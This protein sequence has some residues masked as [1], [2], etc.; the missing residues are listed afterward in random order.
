[1]NQIRNTKRDFNTEKRLVQDNR[2]NASIRADQSKTAKTVH[3]IDDI[4]KWKD[5]K[6]KSD[7]KGY[8]TKRFRTTAK[9][10]RNTGHS[11]DDAVEENPERFLIDQYLPRKALEN[12][13]DYNSFKK[14]LA[15]AYVS[16][17]S[18]K[19]LISNLSERGFVQ[20][21]NTQKVQEAVKQ[22]TGVKQVP[23]SVPSR[24]SVAQKIIGYIKNQKIGEVKQTFSKTGQKVYRDKT[25]RF[26]SIKKVTKGR[27]KGLKKSKKVMKKVK[28]KEPPKSEKRE[29]LREKI[30]KLEK[31][32]GKKK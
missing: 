24:R 4:S 3:E 31:K 17:P 25:G 23:L 32:R 18:L 8:D 6:S 16:N 20:L 27:A 19:N 29:L 15:K 21:Y 5:N 2:S 9:I 22:N 11:G 12:I 26:A 7:L 13:K 30:K 14:E 1:M 28:V 10:K